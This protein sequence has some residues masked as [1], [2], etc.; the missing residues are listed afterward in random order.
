MRQNLFS[1]YVYSI[2]FL[3]SN[4]HVLV[5]WISLYSGADALSDRPQIALV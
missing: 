3:H 1:D 2:A 4:N 5:K